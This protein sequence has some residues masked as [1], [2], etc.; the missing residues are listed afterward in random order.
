MADGTI[1]PQ[2]LT[3]LLGPELDGGALLSA[4]P[5]ASFGLSIVGPSAFADRLETALGLSGPILSTGERAAQLVPALRSRP[6]FGRH[7]P[8]RTPSAWL[9]SCFTGETRCD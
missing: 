4:A 2:G 5:T 7:R 1:Q 3:L 6:G 8:T 9:R